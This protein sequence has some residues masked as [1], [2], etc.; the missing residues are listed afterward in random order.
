MR[1]AKAEQNSRPRVLLV[2]PRF[3]NTTFWS[4]NE[5]LKIHGARHTAPP[6]GLLTVASL[7]PTTWDVRLVDRNVKPVTEAD[8]AWAD[9]VLTGGMFPQ[10]VDTLEV[11]AA[12]QAM[13]LPV[14]VGG[15]A[16]T[17]SPH[18]FAAADFLVLGE[19]EGVIEHFVRAWENGERTGRFEAEKFQA[20]VTKSPI[21]R[22]DLVDFSDYL[23][24]SVQ[25][26]RGCPFTC[27]FCDIIE[28]YGRVPRTKTNDQM[29]AELD[30]LFALGYRGHVDF[31]DDNLIGN[32]KAV[33][34]FLPALRDWQRQHGC[35][36]RFSTEAS[37][38]LADDADLLDMMRHANFFAIFVGIESP[39]P[40]T[41]VHT[42]KK[43]NTR[44]DIAE[45][46]HKINEAGL[47]I[48]GG[49]II[50]FDTEKPKTAEAMVAFIEKADIPVPMVGLLTALPNTQMTRRLESEGRLNVDY[51]YVSPE[52]SDQ[53]T[54]GLNFRTLR[55]RRDVLADYIYVLSKVYDRK[56]FFGRVS[57]MAHRLNR[58]TLFGPASMIGRREGLTYFRRLAW[59][60]TVVQPSLARYFWPTLIRCARNRN[61]SELYM[62]LVNMALF[63]HL[64][65]FSKQ[66]IRQLQAAIDAID[67]GEWTPPPVR[68]GAGVKVAEVPPLSIAV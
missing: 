37:I 27:E 2:F 53:Y 23:Q 35:P 31:V 40:A 7:L 10:Q 66:V 54:A 36:F 13:A 25:F 56:A 50:G 29:L 19:A 33:K 67:R 24:V 9:L 68:E 62:A 22:F 8:Y 15:P 59:E 38:N 57:R 46:I 48:M 64:H 12:A 3:G 58:P 60:M 55:P 34:R 32:K 61:F 65:R 17:S 51:D 45:S 26:S 49:F 52:T 14:C 44:R 21:P 42:Q 18:V 28:L 5:A 47:F 63:L 4:L 1:R 39:D 41:L 6:L 11:I 43:Q 30:R 16:V 20:D